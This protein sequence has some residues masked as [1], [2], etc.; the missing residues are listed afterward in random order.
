VTKNFQAAREKN[1]IYLS[2]E[3]WAELSTEHTNRGKALDETKRH[4]EVCES[5]LRT[6][7]EQFEQN[8]RLLG[9]REGELKAATEEREK[10]TRELERTLAELRR[11]KTDLDGE[12]RKRKRGDVMRREWRDRVDQAMEDVD[13]LRHKIGTWVKVGIGDRAAADELIM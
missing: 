6:T 3:S 9:T 7:R 12:R 11:T 5:Q 2:P 10:R 13:G 4:A 8:L 1:G